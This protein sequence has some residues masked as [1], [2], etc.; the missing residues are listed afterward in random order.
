[1]LIYTGNTHKRRA[2][3]TQSEG[4]TDSVIS[5]VF[6]LPCLRSQRYTEVS[7]YFFDEPLSLRK[8]IF[9]H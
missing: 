3:C 4:H 7:S 9:T 5:P 8:I 1:M 2:H 6:A